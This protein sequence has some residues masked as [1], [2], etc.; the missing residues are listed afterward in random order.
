[1]AFKGV[2]AACIIEVSKAIFFGASKPANSAIF[3][4]CSNSYAVSIMEDYEF[5]REP[6][7]I[8]YHPATK[9][10]GSA[11][12]FQMVQTKANT[13]WWSMRSH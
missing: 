6:V 7:S 3:A 8:Y 4:S 9:I 10:T 13:V 11:S 1:M 2:I 12:Y 5:L